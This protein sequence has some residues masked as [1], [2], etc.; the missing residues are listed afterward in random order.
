MTT[1]AALK[2]QILALAQTTPAVAS[3][4]AERDE[5][6]I[7]AALPAT[8]K[9]VTKLLGVGTVLS[10]LGS[11]DGAALLD[12]LAA[13]ASTNRPVF[14]GLELLKNTNL[15]I[16]LPETIAQFNALTAA[17]LMTAASRDKLLALAQISIPV[18]PLDVARA[19][20]S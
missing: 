1:P 5:A 14:W 2:A 13:L 8:T 3:A 15:D 9:T 19:L 7:A 12:N 10:T 11:A 6:T 20:E 17:G 18:T 16:G 4:L